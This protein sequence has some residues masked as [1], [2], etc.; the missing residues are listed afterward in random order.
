MF[1]PLPPTPVSGRSMAALFGPRSLA[2]LCSV[3]VVLLGFLASASA[4]DK[5]ANSQ[6]SAQAQRGRLYPATHRRPRQLL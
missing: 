2:F 1:K 4:Q 3:I 5:P 6:P